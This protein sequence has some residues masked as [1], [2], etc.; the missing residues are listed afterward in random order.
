MINISLEYFKKIYRNIK[1][2]IDGYYIFK[3]WKNVDF[4]YLSISFLAFFILLL[5]FVVYSTYV[6]YQS[7]LSTGSANKAK[8]NK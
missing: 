3:I 8:I 4:V 7:Y 2:L 6:N 1:I 5:L